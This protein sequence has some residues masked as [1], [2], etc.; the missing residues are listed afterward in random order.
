MESFFDAGYEH[1]NGHSDPDLGFYSVL[2]GPVERLYTQVLLAS[3]GIAGK[4]VSEGLFI[5]HFRL[6]III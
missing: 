3:P 5:T 6:L 1:I 2:D 4:K